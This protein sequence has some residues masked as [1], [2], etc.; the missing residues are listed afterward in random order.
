MES[1]SRLFRIWLSTRTLFSLTTPEEES[2][3]IVASVTR[4]SHILA[5]CENSLCSPD[6][7]NILYML[8]PTRFNANVTRHIVYKTQRWALRLSEFNFTMEHIPVAFNT[9]ADLLTPWGAPGNG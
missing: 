1:F 7:K 4:L 6:H 8:S 2:Y 5:G 3:A 9:W